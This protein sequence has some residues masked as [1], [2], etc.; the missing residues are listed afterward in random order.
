MESGNRGTLK[1]AR[2]LKFFLYRQGWHLFALLILVPAAYYF[3]DPHLG[4]GSFLGLGDRQWFHLSILFTILHQVWVWLG[5]RLQLGWG[6]F[7]KI[8]GKWDMLFWGTTF[9]PLLLTRPLFLVALSR[10]NQ[11]TLIIDS[12]VAVV[13]GILLLIPAVYTLYSVF[14]YFGL[15][16]ALGG[17]HFRESYRKM[18]LVTEGAFRYSSNAMYQYA[19]L[20]LW[21]IALLNQSQAGLIAA[22]FQH[23]YIWVHYYTVEKPDMD[24]IFHE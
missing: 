23:L 3:A 14:R 4:E 6:T 1:E 22:A 5:F 8:F 24:L 11:S 15:K 19:F 13:L 12:G 20:L 10:G 9:F 18:P 21:S 16:R 7:T 17:D 2:S